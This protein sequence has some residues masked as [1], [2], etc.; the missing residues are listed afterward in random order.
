MS[1]KP[2]CAKLICYS[3]ISLADVVFLA[4]VGQCCIFNRG[5]STNN[6]GSDNFKEVNYHI[7]LQD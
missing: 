4:N 2:K 7:F 1:Y 3:K 5:K 6:L